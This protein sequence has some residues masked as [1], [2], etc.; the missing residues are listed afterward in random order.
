MASHWVALGLVSCV[1]CAC[2]VFEARNADLV[3][4]QASA[5]GFRGW[6]GARWSEILYLQGL[7]WKLDP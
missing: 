4:R 6:P 1:K 5:S 3:L 7:D 2:L